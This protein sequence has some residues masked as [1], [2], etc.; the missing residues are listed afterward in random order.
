MVNVSLRNNPHFLGKCVKKYHCFQ[1]KILRTLANFANICCY[2]SNAMP[3]L[4][5]MRGL[6]WVRSL[7][8]KRKEK[9]NLTLRKISQAIT[10]IKIARKDMNIMT[11]ILKWNF[12]LPLNFVCIAYILSYDQKKVFEHRSAPDCIYMPA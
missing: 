2:D 7:K 1:A 10:L 8:H 11:L 5:D 12:T 4:R 3:N 6:T 9:G